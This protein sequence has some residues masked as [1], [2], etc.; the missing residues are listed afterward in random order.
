MIACA[1]AATPGPMQAWLIEDAGTWTGKSTMWMTAETPP[2]VS[3]ATDVVTP[4]LDGRFIRCDSVGEIPGMGAFNGF[5]LT[6][7]DNVSQKFQS[8]WADTMG[9]GMMWGTGTLSADGKALTFNYTYNCP[10]TKK[11]TAIRMVQTRTGTDTRTMEMWGPDPST[12]KEFRM[13]EIKYKRAPSK[14]AATSAE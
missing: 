14:T 2:T 13:L 4:M 1:A 10:M 3:E 7:F 6:G 12:A 9:T 8:I 5:A 11:P